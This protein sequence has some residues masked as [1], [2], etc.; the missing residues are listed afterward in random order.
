LLENVDRLIRSP[1]SQRGRDF[2]I[3]LKCFYDNGYDVEWR[4]INGAEYG[5]PQKR[6]RIFIFAYS[7]FT[8][9]Y[10]TNQHKTFSQYLSKSTIFENFPIKTLDNPI[11]INLADAK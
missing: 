1:A 5:F 11:S 6:R 10:K 7:K 2:G 3:M 9:F 8:N 4:V